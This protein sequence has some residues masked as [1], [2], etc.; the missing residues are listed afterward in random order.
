MSQR[1]PTCAVG[2]DECC[3]D[4]TT[5][6]NNAL[7]STPPSRPNRPSL[8]KILLSLEG[9]AAKQ[10]ALAHVLQAL[11]IIYA[12]FVDPTVQ[13]YCRVYVLLPGIFFLC[14]AGVVVTILS[15]E[16]GGIRRITGIFIA[17][18]FNSRNLQCVCARS[19]GCLDQ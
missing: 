6:I 7:V 11:Q 5:V 16:R 3:S 13:L 14:R 9:T 2:L 18:N 15:V 19:V 17:I 12:R 8:A 1:P 10:Q 4:D